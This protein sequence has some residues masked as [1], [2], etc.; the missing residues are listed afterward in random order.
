VRFAALILL[1]L[2]ART[3]ESQTPATT[4]RATVSGVVYDSVALRPLA[5]ATVQL[6]DADN[7]AG[8][9]RTSV[10]DSLGWFMFDDVADGRYLLGFLHPVLESL[11]DSRCRVDGALD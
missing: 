8:T 3:G 6:V 2:A 10:T 4:S 5:A 7:V 11:G 9:V 1:L